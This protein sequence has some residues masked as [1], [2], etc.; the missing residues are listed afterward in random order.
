MHIYVLAKSVR[1]FNAWIALKSALNRLCPGRALKNVPVD[2]R[3]GLSY[4]KC[5]ITR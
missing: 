2:T 5:W 4:D 3:Y 1:M